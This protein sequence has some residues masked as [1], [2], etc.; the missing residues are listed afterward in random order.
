MNPIKQ[1]PSIMKIRLKPIANLTEHG[2]LRLIVGLIRLKS[3]TL[4]K[5]L[6]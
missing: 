6:I 5:S 1:N 4:P 3:T 2:H